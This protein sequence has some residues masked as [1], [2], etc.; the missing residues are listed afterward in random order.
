MKRLLSVLTLYVLAGSASAET[1]PLVGSL[2]TI[3]H[4]RAI[5]QSGP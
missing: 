4:V 3:S 2:P 1:S 5:N